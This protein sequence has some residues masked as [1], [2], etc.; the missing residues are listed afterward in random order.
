MLW[1]R[2]RFVSVLLVVVLL[3]A[4]AVAGPSAAD[5]GGFG[6]VDGG[7]HEPAIDALVGEG[8][9]EGTECGEGLFCPGE[10]ILRSVMAVWLVRALGESPSDGS[11]SRFSDVDSDVWWSPYVERLADLGVTKGCGGEPPRFCPDMAVT[12]GQ[13]ATFLVRAFDLEPAGSAG[14]TDTAGSTH[15]A[16]IDALAAAN[17]T[18]GCAKAPSRYC[19][20]KSVTRAQMATFLARALDLI[21]RPSSESEPAT[22]SQPRL[23]YIDDGGLFVISGDGTDR[24][25][26]VQADVTTLRSWSAN[27]AYLTYETVGRVFVVKGDGTGRRELNTQTYWPLSWSPDGSRLSYYNLSISDPNPDLIVE[28]ADGTGHRQLFLPD[29]ANFYGSFVWSPDGSRIVYS[30]RHTVVEDYYSYTTRRWV[31]VEDAD[32]TD[33]RQLPDGA[34][35]PEE[36][37]SIWSPD[38]TRLAYNTDEG[39]FVENADGTDRRQLPDGTKLDDSSYWAP[40]GTRL[41]YTHRATD[42]PGLYIVDVDG[43]NQRLLDEAQ[44]L[45]TVL[46]W[47]PDG[48]G[49]LYTVREQVEQ[50]GWREWQTRLFLIDIDDISRYQLNEDATYYVTE[51]DSFRNYYD[52]YLVAGWSPDGTRIIYIARKDDGGDGGTF[53]DSLFV[54]DTDGTNRR[55]LPIQN[56][57]AGDVPVQSVYTVSWSPDSTQ[58]AFAY[59]MYGDGLEGGLYV[60]DTDG[61]NRRQ[62]AD[63]PAKEPCASWSPDGTYLAYGTGEGYFVED[64]DGS[65]RWQLAGSDRW[66]RAGGG[67]SSWCSTWQPMG[68]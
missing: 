43:T 26:I 14:F 4:V 67:L 48:T 63:T 52:E 64:A 53:N 3:P 58:L 35:L 29:E 19:P 42:N 54:V 28:N 2:Y 27:G 60:E 61:T 24:R 34:S 1:R 41:S 16:G 15:E 18:A 6:D 56:V 59:H 50:E 45:I 13:M 8:I 10:P 44:L 49:L 62:L 47:S 38:G 66:Q 46:G 55:E 68:S 20:G 25:Q 5:T 21:P 57:H 33:R 32:G 22:I 23:A 36:L 31:F 12:R 40:D 37:S 11:G 7:V 65:D 9:V 39:T 30:A 51:Y 17:V